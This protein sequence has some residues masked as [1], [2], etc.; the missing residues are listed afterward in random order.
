MKWFKELFGSKSALPANDAHIT[1]SSPPISSLLKN[2]E[3]V[4]YRPTDGGP[5]RLFGKTKPLEALTEEELIGLLKRG[6]IGK[7]FHLVLRCYDEQGRPPE[8]RQKVLESV[9][10]AM[11]G[12][13]SD[14]SRFP[15]MLTRR[16]EVVVSTSD[17]SASIIMSIRF[18]RDSDAVPFIQECNNIFRQHGFRA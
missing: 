6:E 15:G 14:R 4:Y 1:T 8:I 7:Q 5:H 10:S 16:A 9:Y 11:L 13:C 3:S 18:A 2:P 12:L 17:N